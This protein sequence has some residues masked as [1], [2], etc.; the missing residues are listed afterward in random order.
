MSTIADKMN[1]KQT[2]SD[3]AKTFIGHVGSQVPSEEWIA[4]EGDTVGLILDGQTIYVRDLK[5]NKS[6]HLIGNVFSLKNNNAVKYK[7][8]ELDQEISFRHVHVHNL[9]SGQ[10]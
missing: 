1:F 5:L 3:R 9:I 10:G 2:E 7:S 8:L 6:D 4:Q